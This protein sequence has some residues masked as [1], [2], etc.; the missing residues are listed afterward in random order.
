MAFAYDICTT[1][2]MN[3]VVLG[4]TLTEVQGRNGAA[5]PLP[6][7]VAKGKVAIVEVSFLDALPCKPRPLHAHSSTH[8]QGG[9]GKMMRKN[10]TA[11]RHLGA[12]L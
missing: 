9:D 3:K 8:R 2:N 1:T 7:L 5:V 11:K 12:I 6:V 10:D 4:G